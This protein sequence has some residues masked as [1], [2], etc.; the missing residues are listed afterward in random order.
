MKQK[1]KVFNAYIFECLNLSKSKIVHEKK[2]GFETNNRN[3]KV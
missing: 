2:M 1:F 3:S